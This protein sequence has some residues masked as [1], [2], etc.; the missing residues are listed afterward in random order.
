MPSAANPPLPVEISLLFDCSASVER[1]AA[2]SSRVFRD[3]LLDEFP[4]ASI[5]IYGFS[6]N[7]V[8]FARPTRDSAAL[9]KAMDL[10]AAIP[11]G[12]T[13]LFGSIADTVRDAATTGANV[14]RM[15]VVFSHG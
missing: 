1:I 2:M 15:L 8:R 7:L 6:D 13:P 11:K 9:K 4:N 14:V 10:V 3:N 12:D 5:A